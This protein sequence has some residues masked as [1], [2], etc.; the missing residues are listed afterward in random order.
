ME[1]ILFILFIIIIS[2]FCY[3]EGQIENQSDNQTSTQQRLRL[4]TTTSTENTGLLDVLIPAFTNRTGIKVDV[5]AVGTGKAITLG[6]NGDVDIIM[7]HAR[8]RED[9]FVSD[10]YG[11]NRR[12]LMHNDFVILGP[13]DDPAGISSVKDAAKAFKKIQLTKSSF[14]SRGDDSGTNTKEKELW[15]TAG[16]IPA[17]KWYKEAGQGMGAVIT[18]ANDMQGY[19]LSDR[20]TYLAL[21]DK[22]DL[23]VLV[24]GDPKLFNPY[25][26]I[27]VNPAIHDG[28]NY[29]DAMRLIAFLT[30]GEGQSIIKN[31]QKNGEKL[32]YPDVIK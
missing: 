13:P 19:T 25:G 32:F 9:S 5:I 28:I 22:I 11:V 23:A 30:S 4:A 24:E 20:G 16:V 29:E 7:V 17:G 2:S 27:A 10:G 1:K 12:N 31:F 18:M 21:R 6:E 8:S 26:V 3:A 14:I 15:N